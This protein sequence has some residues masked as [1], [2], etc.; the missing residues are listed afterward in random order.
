MGASESRW[1]RKAV[2][3]MPDDKSTSNSSNSSNPS[4]SSTTKKRKSKVNILEAN[5]N[6]IF[7]L[8]KFWTNNINP[9][10]DEQYQKLALL[11]YNKVFELAPHVK[12]TLFSKSN[13]P[14]A[15]KLFLGMFG[16]LI[17]QLGTAKSYQSTIR[18][19]RKLGKMHSK[20]NVQL[21]YYSVLLDA[22]NWAM[23]EYFGSDIYNLRVRFCMSQLYNVVADIMTS[24][25]FSS[26]IEKEN[27]AS[28]IQFDTFMKNL[29][30]CL[31]N[32]EGRL[33][34]ELF[35]KQHF[36]SELMEFYKV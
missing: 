5:S 9:L 28:N 1:E 11:Q 32:K 10:T 22:F 18:Q 30:S 34:L 3:S 15:S 29:E 35:M 13:V 19:L 2:E 33:Y 25:D 20:R 7:V 36:C 8:N 14:H 24:R 17:G 12:E 6:A 4:N 16:W 31:E 21:E 27:I 23:T 26:M